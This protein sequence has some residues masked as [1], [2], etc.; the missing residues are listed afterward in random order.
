MEMEPDFWIPIVLFVVTGLILYAF[1]FYRYKT[2][3]DLQ[4]TVRTAIDKGQELT[5]EVLERLGRPRPLPE[6]DLRRG[7]V[8]VALG[9]AIAVFGLALNEQDAVRPMLAIAAFPAI[10]GVAYLGLWRF[11]SRT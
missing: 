8:L 5:P 4:N 1:F 2:R 10:V 6:A 11:T 9:V 7:V 3:H